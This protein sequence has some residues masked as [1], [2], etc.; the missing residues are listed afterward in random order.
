MFLCRWLATLLLFLVPC[1]FAQYPKV[2]NYGTLRVR[3]VFS[4]DRHCE[5]QLHV[6]LMGGASNVPV[7]DAYTNNECMVD[8][9]TLPVGDYHMVISGEGVEET[10]S[11]VFQVDA[12]KSSQS[13]FVTVKRKGEGETG[14]VNKSGGPATVAAVDL[15]VP[16]NAKR[17]YEK[18]AAPL[19]KG[20]WNKAKE[21]I[22]KALA[23]Y[24]RFAAA[25]NDLGVVYARLGDR[26]HEREALQKA[27]SLNDHFAEA[28]VNL[29]KMEIVD[30]NFPGAE[31]FLVKAASSDPS[32]PETLMLLANVELLDRHFD[33]AIANCRKVHLLPHGSET[34]VHYI[35]ARALMHENRRDEAMS[36]LRTF[37]VEEPSGP[38]ADAVRAELGQLQAAN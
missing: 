11:G 14:S 26:I 27:V 37:L 34:L 4:D 23:I 38:R 35:A 7:A 6:V 17:E 30:R 28:Y 5:V 10:D 31:G 33:E 13:L 12:R 20:N 3:I 15:N 16:E 8:F 24:P 19:S 32:N 2:D 25:Y 18:A 9:A 29:G 22:L 21:M 1:S 36:E